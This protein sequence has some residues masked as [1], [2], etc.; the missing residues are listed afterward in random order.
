MQADD[1]SSKIA[2]IEQRIAT[3]SAQLSQAQGVVQQWTDVNADLSRNAAEACAKNQG[4]GRGFL[5]TAWF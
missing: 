3:L 5:W 2:E 1:R 4:M